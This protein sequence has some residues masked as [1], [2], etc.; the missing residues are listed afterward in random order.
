MSLTLVAFMT[1]SLY[2]LATVLQGMLLI[3]FTRKIKTAVLILSVVAVILHAILLHLWIDH[4]AGQ[5]LSFANLFSFT[6]WLITVMVFIFSLRKSIESLF[7]LVFPVC[8]LSIAFVLLSS[9]KNM[10]N[11]IAE[12]ITLF[13]IILSEVAF[14]VLSIAGLLAILLA[15]QECC[16]RYKKMLGIMSQLPA[17]ESMEAFLFQVIYCGFI[18]LSIVLISSIYFYYDLLW[19]RYDVLQKAL[20][21]TLAWIVFAWLLIGRHYM[22]WRGRKAINGTLFAVLLL[23]I[24][25]FGF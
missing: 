22:G 3:C 20:L 4:A 14:C 15:A 12:P 2:L 5:N 23:F 25:Y 11:T 13:H 9:Q 10:V 16:L 6:A 21:V 19:T 8:A 17:V 7:L 24:S 18:L 1:V